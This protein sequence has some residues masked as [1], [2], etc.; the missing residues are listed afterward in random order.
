MAIAVR[1]IAVGDSGSGTC[2]GP[3]SLANIQ[4]AMDD[5]NEDPDD[6]TFYTIG[7]EVVVELEKKLVLVRK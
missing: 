6:Y 4:I 3:E 5:D 2:Y 7:E 1:Y